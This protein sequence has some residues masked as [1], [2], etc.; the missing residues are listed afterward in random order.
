M[1]E[2]K[3]QNIIII[4]LVIIAV[5]LTALLCIVLFKDKKTLTKTNNQ[6]NENNEVSIT[7]KGLSLENVEA[8]TNTLDIYYSE[9]ED[10]FCYFDDIEECSSKK[11]T[12]KVESKDANKI[13]T[14]S[15]RYVFYKDNGK[16]KVYDY[17]NNKYYVVNIS[18]NYKGYEFEVDNV[19]EEFVGIIY[20]EKEG[21]YRTFYS[22]IDDITLYDKKYREL[23]FLSKDYLESI[24]SECKESN[25]SYVDYDECE[26]KYI[27]LLSTKEEKVIKQDEI[28]KDKDGYYEHQ[29]FGLLYNKNG[30]YIYHAESTDALFYK[31]IYNENLKRIVSNTNE[32]ETDIGSDGNLYVNNKG[33]VN[34]YNNEGKKIKSSKK[35]DVKQI[36]GEYIVAIKDNNLIITTVDSNETKLT[37]WNKKYNYL[38]VG[39]SG[40]YTDNGKH[41]IYLVVQDDKAN[42]NDIWEYCKTH[43]YCGGEIESKKDL[44]E[45]D[46]GYEYYYIPETKEVGKIPTYIGGYAK[47]VLYLY[48]KKETKVTVTFDN[49]ESLTTTYPKYD[50]NWIV[51]AKPNGDLYDLNNKY[52][53]ALYWEEKPNHNIDFKEG[54]YVTKDNA[55]EFLEEKLSYIGFNQK[56]R[57]EFIMYWLPVLERN[58]KN[59]VYFE[60]TNE[61]EK[62]SKINISPKP[63]SL[64]RVAIHVKKINNEVKIKE[65][66]LTKFNRKGFTAVEWGGVIH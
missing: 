28:Y 24:T 21:D 7:S 50:K 60:L 48:P 35:Y 52:Y 29:L 58:E 11:I 5:L 1:K 51:N 20:T 61:R 44:D 66:K 36:V 3:K 10:I 18:A 17:K 64:L 31:D 13:D 37:S 33:I 62:Y 27:S 55:I 54:F 9:R 15:D 14:Y 41:G 40:W 32:F 23:G 59:L 39:L 26:D 38:H 16:I 30:T 46:L 43:N 25:T 34:V 49:P 6:N 57:N 19:T 2:N 45:Y 47:P 12:I 4:L 53:Y 56:E 22:V 42:K 63:D 65:Q 8:Y